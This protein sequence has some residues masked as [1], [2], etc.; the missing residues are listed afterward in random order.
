MGEQSV[1]TLERDEVLRRMESRETYGLDDRQVAERIRRYGRN[2]FQAEKRKKRI[3]RFFEQFADFMILVLIAAAVISLLVSYWNGETDFTDP[4]IILSIVVLNAILGVIQEEKA[5]KS[6]EALKRLSAPT[7]SVLRNGVWQEIGAVELVPGDIIQLEAGAYVPAD[8]RLLSCVNLKVDESALTGESLPVKKNP[9]TRYPAETLL[10]DRANMLYSTCI[11]TNGHG[12]AVVTATGMQTEVGK[13]ADM[14][15]NDAAPSTP[16][17]K[18]LAVIGKWLGMAA[19]GICIIIFIM[20]STQGREL[21]DM[22]MT[23]VSLAVAAIPEALPGMVTIMLS[24]GVQRMAA[25]KA[26]VKRLTAVET[27]GSATWICSD[28]T[29][30]LTQNEMTIV[31]LSDSGRFLARKEKNAL[32]MLQAAALCCNVKQQTEHGKTEWS[33]EAAEKAIVLALKDAGGDYD[34]LVQMIKRT[35]E[36]PFD[37]GRKCMTTKHE[38]QGRSFSITKGAPDFLLEKCTQYDNNGRILPMTLAVREKIR[39]QNLNMTGQGLRVLAVTYKVF[40]TERAGNS[41]LTAGRMDQLEQGLVFLGLTGMMDPPRS[42]AADCVK[43]CQEAGITPVMI[44]GDHVKTACA[45]AKAVGILK[46]EDTEAVTGEELSRMTQEELEKKVRSYRVFARVSPEH[47]VRIVK[48]LQATGEIV[49][50]T[51]DGVNDA[52][53]LKAADIGCAMGKSGTDVAKNAADMVLL[54]DNFATIV[55]A[56]REGRGIYDNIQKSI[57]FLLSSNIGEIITIFVAILCRLPSPLAA[58]QLLW[59]NLVTDSLPAIALGVEKPEK[60]IMKRPPIPPSQG[61]F[62][63]ELVLQ[64]ILEGV[65]IGMLSQIGYLLGGSTYAFGVLAFSQ[66]FHAFNMRSRRSL[67]SVGVFSNHKM[68]AAFLICGLMQ[69][70]VF[71]VPALAAV[72]E[73][74][75]PG[76]HD[77]ILILSLSFVPIPVVELQKWIHKKKIAP[78]S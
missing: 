38:F 66:L 21:F 6:L 77:W 7:A 49:A 47:K 14:I 62:T 34:R 17:Q 12:K 58:V 42:E 13:I 36:L 41:H 5:E 35:M 10:G 72:F 50:M 64:M 8:A 25:K 76:I 23:S 19:L 2:E 40:D 71:S 60:G 75:T 28:K 16:L 78:K 24:L 61:I 3:V 46:T 68:T 74:V 69:A 31:K 48:A 22:F 18:R 1:H 45:V 39:N 15:L 33:G 11:V 56:V 70:I 20:G 52:P 37:S 29:G 57:H 27:L 55:E 67:F 43:T 44:T 73:I 59:V 65:M 9:L 51:G 4:I 30:T 32:R 53:A 63:R 54:D 26:V